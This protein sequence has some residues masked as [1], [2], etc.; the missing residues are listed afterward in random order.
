[1]PSE[2]AAGIALTCITALR[3]PGGGVRGIATGDVFR[4]LVSRTLAGSWTPLFD[5][6]TRPYQY[7]L[8][9]RAGVDALTARLRA[10]LDRDP[11][12]TVVSLDG[13]SAYDCISR[14]IFCCKLQE[15]APALVP[16]VRMFPWSG[17][18]ILL[19]EC[20]GRPSQHLSGRR[21]RTWGPPGPGIAR[22]WPA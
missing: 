9:T 12:T 18:R 4:R 11:A 8:R 22:T 3:K 20:G 21:M 5:E 7:A 6:A 17:F 14:A 13:R 16:F 19:V 1:M 2:V 10:T 15:V